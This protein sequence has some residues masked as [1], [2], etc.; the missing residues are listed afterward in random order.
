MRFGEG[1]AAGEGERDFGAG[2]GE[3]DFGAGD[4][5]FFADL[6][7]DLFGAAFFVGSGASIVSSTAALANC[8]RD[9]SASGSY[10]FGAVDCR[11]ERRTAIA[12]ERPSRMAQTTA[13]F[14]RV[15]FKI[16]GGPTRRPYVPPPVQTVHH[17]PRFRVSHSSCWVTTILNSTFQST[18]DLMLSLAILRILA[19]AP[20][21][22]SH[23]RAQSPLSMQSSNACAKR[24]GAKLCC[25]PP[26]IESSALRIAGSS[27]P[28]SASVHGGPVSV[29][30][31]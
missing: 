16:R 30:P 9:A 22:A 15:D 4:G 17:R 23:T 12:T 31:S 8:G 25:A 6:F 7:A 21:A 26:A 18:L 19:P 11:R 24:D 3:R 1:D 5:D 10:V 14:R 29:L 13:V 20:H 2:E 28:L 27:L